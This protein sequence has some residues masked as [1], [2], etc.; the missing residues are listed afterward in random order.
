LASSAAA[1]AMTVAAGAVHSDSAYDCGEYVHTH[2]LMA[3][4]QAGPRVGKGGSKQCV[5]AAAAA[6]A[7]VVALMSPR[8]SWENALSGLCL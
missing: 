8:N 6:A 2:P 1:A 5:T 4:K 7:A 3:S